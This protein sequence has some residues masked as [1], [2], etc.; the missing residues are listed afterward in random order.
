M[1]TTPR[2]TVLGHHRVD[3]PFHGWKRNEWFL[4]VQHW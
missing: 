4:S 2:V 3:E 1:Y